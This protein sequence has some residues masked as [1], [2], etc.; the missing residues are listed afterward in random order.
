MLAGIQLNR[1]SS[2]RWIPARGDYPGLFLASSDTKVPTSWHIRLVV[3]I[4]DHCSGEV[5][6]LFDAEGWIAYCSKRLMN[7]PE[8]TTQLPPK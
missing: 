6:L 2:S 4:Q 3:R 7:L 1:M 5:L 8:V